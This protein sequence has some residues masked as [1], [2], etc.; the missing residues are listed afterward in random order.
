MTLASLQAETAKLR[1]R[2]WLVRLL[3]LQSPPRVEM[4]VSCCPSLPTRW[5][6]PWVYP[7][8]RTGSER[9]AQRQTVGH[10]SSLPKCLITLRNGF[11]EGTSKTETDNSRSDNTRS[12]FIL[13]KKKAAAEKESKT[14][15]LLTS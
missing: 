2:G 12:K 11:R 8:L 10:F 1:F 4:P 14:P 13:K 7:L 9:G 6:P 5:Q 3:R 15:F